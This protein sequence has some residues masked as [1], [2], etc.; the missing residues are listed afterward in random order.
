MRGLQHVMVLHR[1]VEMI[2]GQENPMARSAQTHYLIDK[3]N[4]KMHF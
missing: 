4:M 3:V 1:P 2:S